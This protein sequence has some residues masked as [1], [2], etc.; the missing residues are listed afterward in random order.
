[1]TT[2]H[3]AQAV[4]LNIG[5]GG[6]A[7]CRAGISSSVEVPQA[8]PSRSGLRMPSRREQTRLGGGCA[9]PGRRARSSNGAAQEAHL[10][11]NAAAVCSVPLPV[12]VDHGIFAKHGLDVDLVNF[13]GS[14]DQLL[15]AIATG[16]SDA[17]VGMAL[18]WLKPLEQ[19][20]DVKITAGTHGGCLRLLAPV[21]GSIAKLEDLKG[22]VVATADM[23][24]PDKNFFSILLARRGSIPSRMWSGGNIQ[25]NSCVRP[26]TRA[27]RKRSSAATR[28]PISGSRTAS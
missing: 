24:S 5:T 4:S 22:K 16:K 23:A 15:E 9:M 26:S 20:F 7:R 28:A 3:H 17:G 13:G 1:M 6:S 2:E 8:S 21:D 25:V 10:L 12:A 19:G 27:R 11:W 14:T 18:R